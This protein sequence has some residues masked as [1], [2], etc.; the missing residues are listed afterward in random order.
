MLPACIALSTPASTKAARMA[1][2]QRRAARSSGAMAKTVGPAPLIEPPKAPAAIAAL[3][4][5]A[6]PGMAGD[7]AGSA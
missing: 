6:N 1:S 7:R 4:T 2:A 5:A 3:F